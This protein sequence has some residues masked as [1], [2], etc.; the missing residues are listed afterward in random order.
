MPWRSSG[1]GASLCGSLTAGRFAA[2][3]E[4]RF[5]CRACFFERWVDI[6]RDAFVARGRNAFAFSRSARSAGR[7]S[8]CCHRGTCQNPSPSSCRANS[9]SCS[10]RTLPGSNATS[11]SSEGTGTRSAQQSIAV[12]RSSP[13]RYR[14]TSPIHGAARSVG[15]ARAALGA[16]PSGPDVAFARVRRVRR[17]T[18][19][20]V[21]VRYPRMRQ[22]HAPGPRER[23][24]PR[25]DFLHEAASRRSF[26]AFAQRAA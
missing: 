8:L 26:R 22:A 2:S 1:H 6:L 11:S 9:R 14:V 24:C 7:A 16:G 12:A 17:R 4:L 20:R 5:A 21:R 25:P 10:T 3:P 15:P 18:R 23:R 13:P 19:V